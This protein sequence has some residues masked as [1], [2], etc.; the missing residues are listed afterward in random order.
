MARMKSGDAGTRSERETTVTLRL[1][2]EL[3]ERLKAEGGERGFAASIRERLERSFAPAAT[4]GDQETSE[5]LLMAA[6]GAREIGE[7]R[8]PW[9]EDPTAFAVFKTFMAILLGLYQ[10]DGKPSPNLDARLEAVIMAGAAAKVLGDRALD[11]RSRI[12]PPWQAGD[13]P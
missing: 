2:R 3:H 6:E 8:H 1:P 4:G 12:R 10:P 5:L 9:H 7:L 13:E 11:V